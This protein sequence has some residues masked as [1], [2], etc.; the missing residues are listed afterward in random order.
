[1]HFAHFNS[2]HTQLEAYVQLAM[3]QN[4]RQLSGLAQL[5]TH[6][7]NTVMRCLR[8]MSRKACAHHQTYGTK[9]LEA[10]L[11]EYSGYTLLKAVVFESNGITP[12]PCLQTL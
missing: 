3:K 6:N 5:Y 4:Y 2:L 1:M 7:L 10:A 8:Q 12:Q 11:K 9:K